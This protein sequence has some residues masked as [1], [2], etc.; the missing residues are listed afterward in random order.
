M[1]KGGQFYSNSIYSLLGRGVTKDTEDRETLWI[2][3]GVYG[4]PN[5]HSQY[6][7]AVKQC[8]TKQGSVPMIY[9]LVEVSE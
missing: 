1:T 2:I 8:K 6:Y 9:I 4:D 5:T 7:P 3:P